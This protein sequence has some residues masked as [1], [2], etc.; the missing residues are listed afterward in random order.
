M[1]QTAWKY[2]KYRIRREIFIRVY[3]RVGMSLFIF[4]SQNVPL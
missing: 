2:M 1:Y 4:S 3:I